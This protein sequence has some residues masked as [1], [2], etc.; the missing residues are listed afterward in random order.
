MAGYVVVDEWIARCAGRIAA[1]LPDLGP[2]I[3]GERAKQIRHDASHY[4]PEVAAEVY[5]QELGPH[6]VPWDRMIPGEWSVSF[7]L[8]DRS[9]EGV[10]RAVVA[11]EAVLQAHGVSAYEGAHAKFRLESWDDSGYDDK[12]KLTAKQDADLKVWFEAEG[13][14]NTALNAG[15]PPGTRY[16]HL[17]A[18]PPSTVRF[19]EAHKRWRARRGE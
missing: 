6:D 13:A 9:D 3:A 18:S 15:D 8:E 16:G 4:E 14:A 17:G 10:E 1:R 12:H 11:A 19:D 5:V 7:D 2:A